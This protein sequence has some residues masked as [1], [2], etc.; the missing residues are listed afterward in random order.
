MAS[1]IQMASSTE[2]RNIATLFAKRRSSIPK[3]QELSAQP[4]TVSTVISVFRYV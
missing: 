4:Q 3:G 2:P 1:C